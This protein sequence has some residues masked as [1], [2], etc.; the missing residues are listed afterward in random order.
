MLCLVPTSNQFVKVHV[1]FL[2]VEECFVTAFNATTI[3]FK[4]SENTVGGEVAFCIIETLECQ[5]VRQ[6]S[7][8][9]LHF[10]TTVGAFIV[11]V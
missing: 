3:T 7:V 11:L 10:D 1:S 8:L 6:F 9:C 2:F 4:T 5:T